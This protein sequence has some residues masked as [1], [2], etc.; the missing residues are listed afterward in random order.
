MIEIES[1]E[2][3]SLQ[4][5][6]NDLAK[7]NSKKE[8]AINEINDEMDMEVEQPSRIEDNVSLEE[9]VEDSEERCEAE[10]I[11]KATLKYAHKCLIQV[12]ELEAEISKIRKNAANLGSTLKIKSNNF[13]EKL[14]EIEVKEELCEDVLEKVLNLREYLSFS[15]KKPDKERNLKSILTCKK[16]LK[17]YL[18]YPKRPSQIPISDCCK[19]C[20]LSSKVLT[21]VKD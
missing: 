5:Q 1:R 15:D 9:H 19:V 18:K 2:L 8:T 14:D 3:K 21:I 6:I 17:G 20:I 10:I 12:E 11:K 4:K 13:C 16:Y 7:N